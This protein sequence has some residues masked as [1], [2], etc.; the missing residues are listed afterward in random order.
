MQ[1]TIAISITESELEYGV[2]TAQDIP[3][4]YA[5]N[6][7]ESVKLKVRKLP[8]KLRIDN[9]GAVNIANN[10]TGAAEVE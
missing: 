8:M 10:L 2:G 9:K 7:I 4:L 6:L 1:K 5:K 3:L